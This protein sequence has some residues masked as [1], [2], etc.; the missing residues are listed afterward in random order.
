MSKRRAH[1]CVRIAKDICQ[2]VAMG[3]T[4]P[5]ALKKVGALAPTMQT[6]WRWLEEYPEFNAMYMRALQMQAHSHADR[7]VE[8]AEQALANPKMASAVKVA[9]DIYKWSAEMRDP[10]KFSPKAPQEH[11]PPAK[12]IE[13]MRKEVARL[14]NELGIVAQPG[15]VT[16]KQ[17]MRTDPDAAERGKTPAPT[18]N[19]ADMPAEGQ[20]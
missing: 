10:A 20:A 12:N 9:S 1:Y 2:H 8:L 13:E 14:E 11:K 6:L 4:T 19:L 3:L 15:M 7:I 18:P 5:Q 16:A 17:H